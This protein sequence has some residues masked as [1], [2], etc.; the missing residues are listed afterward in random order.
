MSNRGGAPI[1]FRTG[2]AANGHNS[3]TTESGDVLRRLAVFAGLLAVLLSAACTGL[4]DKSPETG[5]MQHRAAE[6]PA[7]QTPAPVAEESE[8]APDGEG[9]RTAAEPAE[10]VAQQEKTVIDAA[11]ATPA[12]PA[13]PV[14]HVPAAPVAAED[15]ATGEGFEQATAPL[16]LEL[17]EKR[18]KETSAIG[19]FTKI[20]LKDQVDEL[21]EKFRDF[22][23]GRANIPLA[24]L[25]QPFDL[26]IMKVLALLQDNDPQLARDI[27]ASR[28][29]IWEIL[30]DREKFARI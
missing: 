12:A 24:Q 8:P 1:L 15:A 10:P 3:V 9:V 28:E 5:E 18:L 16:D 6:T 30:S 4:W 19:F 26:L 29:A 27:L 17:L 2:E 20:A 22:Y 13:E 25:R 23:R 7:M 21:L 11:G 14:E